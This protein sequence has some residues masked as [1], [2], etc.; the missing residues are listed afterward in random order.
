MIKN[1]HFSKNLTTLNSYF[2]KEFAKYFILFFCIV[3]LFVLLEDLYSNIDKML[4]RDLPIPD[5]LKYYTFQVINLTPIIL[6]IAFTVSLIVILFVA[7]KNN[8]IIALRSAGISSYQIAK[9]FWIL[10]ILFCVVSFFL[11]TYCVPFFHEKSSVF[12][13]TKDSSHSKENTLFDVYQLTACDD[14][15]SYYLNRYNA[16]SGIA[17]E[18]LVHGFD[19]S[20]N[21]NRCIHG[22]RAIFVKEDKCWYI[23]SGQ[24]IKLSTTKHTVEN[25]TT[26]SKKKFPELNISPQTMILLKKDPKKLSFDQIRKILHKLPNLRLQSESSPQ[27]SRFFIKYYRFFVSPF[28]KM[29]LLI[30]IISSFLI[31]ADREKGPWA[32][33]N[34]TLKTFLFYGIFY[35]FSNIFGQNSNLHPLCIALFP[36]CCLIIYLLI[37]KIKFK[38]I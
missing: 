6:P 14:F 10:S 4:S 36:G 29:I 21:E 17:Y 38:K 24:E 12:L 2:I 8:E 28:E 25:I 5:I 31:P 19:V 27:N 30:S 9:T 22:E 13:E 16:S 11:E 33:V 15:H 7:Q 37:Q 23:L 26:I 3:T 1:R 34:R 32:C 18:F 20:K 35:N